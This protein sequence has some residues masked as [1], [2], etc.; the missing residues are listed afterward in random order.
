MPHH[1]FIGNAEPIYN[2]EFNEYRWVVKKISHETAPTFIND[3]LTGKSNYRSPSF[4]GWS[5]FINES[6]LI[7]LVNEQEG[8]FTHWGCKK[9]NKEHLV[10]VK[11]ALREWSISHD[12]PAGFHEDKDFVFDEETDEWEMPED[13]KYDWI[14]ARLIW[15]EYWMEWAIN[16]C[17]N[18]ALYNN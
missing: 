16:N 7:D 3:E 4:C 12:L 6:G 13:Q 14:L 9:I 17:E 11:N 2:E 8:P 18:P 1:I 15:L 5:D 10:I